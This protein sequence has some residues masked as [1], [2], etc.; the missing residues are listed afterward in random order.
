MDICDLPTELILDISK[1]VSFKDFSRL[2]LVN[3]RH[4]EHLSP[5]LYLKLLPLHTGSLADEHTYTHTDEGSTEQVPFTRKDV[6][7]WAIE[8]GSVRTL[9]SIDAAETLQ[10]SNINFLTCVPTIRR[11]TDGPFGLCPILPLHLAALCG[12]PAVVRYFLW[13]GADVN[14]TVAGILRPIHLAKTGEIVQI[15]MASG[16]CLDTVDGMTPL[17]CSLMHGANSSATSTFLQLGADPNQANSYDGTTPAQVAVD[18]RNVDALKVLLEA[19][20][21]A[22]QPLPG[23]GHLIYRAVLLT[24]LK[25]YKYIPPGPSKAYQCPQCCD[26][27]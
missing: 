22:R 26:F 27:A 7:Q 25:T 19:G 11:N 3:Q 5:I 9:D 21:D 6:L 12:E 13:K 20:A 4:R 23:G 8:H 15:L 24:Q 14:A 16:S 2:L 17:L 1:C 18:Q 10:P